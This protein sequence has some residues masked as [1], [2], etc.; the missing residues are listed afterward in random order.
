MKIKNMNTKINLKSRL[1]LFGIIVTAF[2]SALISCKQNPEIEWISTTESNPWIKKEV[3]QSKK[4]EA[5]DEVTIDLTN[6]AQT[7]K[8]F[9]AC[10]N[11]LGWTSLSR[12]KEEERTAIMKELFQPGAGANF[13]ICRMPVGANDFSRDW[14]SYNETEGDFEMKNFSIANDIETLVPFIHAAQKLNP[15]LEIWASPWSP[16]TWMKWN[17]HYACAVPW[18]GLAEQFKNLLPADKQGKE[19]TN[20]FIQEEKYFAAYALYFSKFIESYKNQGIR[21]GMVMPQNEFNSC[22]I[23]PSCTWT[24]AA[25][26]QFISKYLGPA[27]EKQGVELFFGTMERPNE[28]LVDTILNDPDAGKYIKGVGF[29]W[30]GKEA[31]PGIYQRYPG[32]MLYQT[33]QECGDGKNDWKYCCYAWSLMKHYMENGASAYL[34]WN[35]S[36]DEGGFS[37]WGWQQ[38]SLVTVNPESNT[39]RFNHEYYLLK[40][41]SHYVKPWA[42]RLKNAGSFDNLLAFVNPDGSIVIIVQND[43]KTVRK[44]TFNLGKMSFSADLEPDSFSTF[45]IAAF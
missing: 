25:L 14:Y 40:H 28:A 38:N 37:R 12:L 9:G 45:S 22:Q 24:A 43:Q 33:E 42:K 35:I 17:K 27:M 5:T 8:G 10:F 31:I 30:A 11:E 21:I 2:G 26:A 23:F 3:I 16:P 32:L 4:S 20:M 18:P 13:T 7:I 39:Y 34:Y 29:Q 41:V 1:F 15:E 44:I 6:T 19:G 36:L